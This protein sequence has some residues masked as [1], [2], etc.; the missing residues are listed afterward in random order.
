[1]SEW[2]T[3]EIMLDAYRQG[4]FP[5]AQDAGDP[6]LFWLS[7]TERGILPIGGVHLSRSMKKFMR[8]SHWTASVNR[9]FPQVVDGCAA[10]SETWINATLQELYFELQQMGHAH[11]IEIWDQD[12]LIGGLFGLSLG[13]AFFAESMFSHQPNASKA[14]L[15][16]TSDLLKRSG[17]QLW[18]TQYPTEH[19]A[20]MGGI[21]VTRMRYHQLLSKALKDAA[22]ISPAPLPSPQALLQDTVQIS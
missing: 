7:P 6:R 21:T 4:A 3:P 18:D 19:L 1:M 14:A 17:F 2:L 9:A 16:W 13:G 8:Q 5:M 20:S 10:R 15:L 11:S 12:Q 22:Q